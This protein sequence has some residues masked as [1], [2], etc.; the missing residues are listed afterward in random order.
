MNILFAGLIAL[1]TWL[2]L[3]G[4]IMLRQ[5]QTFDSAPV[6]VTVYAPIAQNRQCSARG[7]APVF[8]DLDPPASR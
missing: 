1:G 3:H 4:D 5:P 2:F 8:R 6:K 7:D